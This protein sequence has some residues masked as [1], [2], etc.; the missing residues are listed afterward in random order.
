MSSTA[1]TLRTVQWST[2]LGRENEK[3]SSGSPVLQFPLEDTL[4]RIRGP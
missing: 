1:E 3:L 2:E 4:V